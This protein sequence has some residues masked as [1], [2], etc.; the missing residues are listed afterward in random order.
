MRISDC[1]SDV[2]SSDLKVYSR[3]A[4]P[5]RPIDKACR[6]RQS[7]GSTSMQKSGTQHR[8]AAGHD[9]RHRHHRHRLA[10][11]TCRGP[12]RES[13]PRPE[14]HNHGRETSVA[15]S[16]E[17]TTELQSLMSTSYAVLC[18]KKQKNA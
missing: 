14:P 4:P 15:R 1:S 16:E 5:V 8:C 13:E 12:K 11:Q 10:R 7:P 9:D 17:H 6:A 18:L 3:S 2:C